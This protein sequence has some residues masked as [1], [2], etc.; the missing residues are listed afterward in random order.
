MLTHGSSQQSSHAPNADG[1]ERPLRHR[2]GRVD[3]NLRV[4]DEV[5]GGH[6]TP[7]AAVG[8]LIVDA[9][10]NAMS[11]VTRFAPSPTGFLHLGHAFSALFAW[12]RAREA[13]GRFLLRLEDID[14]APLP[15]GIRRGDPGRPG[16][17]RPRLG[18]RGAGAVAR[19]W[20]SIAPRWMRWRRAG[21][22]IRASA[23]RADIQREME[24]SAAAPH[25]PDGAPLYP[26]TCRDAVARR[27]RRA[28]RCRRAPRAAARHGGGRW[29][30]SPRR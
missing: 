26:G 25:A 10:R 6:D 4:G 20:R 9:R 17:A 15:A 16:L 23:R 5:N 22:C 14:P 8:G 29:P 30:A 12:R 19:I 7:F 1:R 13:G 21:C 3:H 28:H 18:R 27:T 11:I 24:Q 2:Y